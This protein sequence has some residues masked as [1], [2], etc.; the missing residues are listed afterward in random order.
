M[1]HSVLL[2]ILDLAHSKAGVKFLDRFLC[3]EE[4]AVSVDNTT[5]VYTLEGLQREFALVEFEV[6]GG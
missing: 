2:L 5:V 1:L 6:E 3:S 4:G